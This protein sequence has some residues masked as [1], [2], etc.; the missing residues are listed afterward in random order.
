MGSIICSSVLMW[1]YK[2]LNK[3]KKEQCA[4]EDIDEDMCRDL[5]DQSPLFR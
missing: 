4:R 1:K 5:G 3:E 2:A